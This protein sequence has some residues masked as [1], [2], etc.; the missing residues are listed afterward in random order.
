MFAGA[1]GKRKGTSSRGGRSVLRLEGEM[2]MEMES[3]GR[4][5]QK[6]GSI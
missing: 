2:E 4:V 5:S 3:A 1:N 6:Q